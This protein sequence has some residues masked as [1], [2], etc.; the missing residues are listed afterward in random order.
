M[1]RMC[2]ALLKRTISWCHA[3]FYNLTDIHHIYIS[4]QIFYQHPLQRLRVS[5]YVPCSKLF[6]CFE[7]SYFSRLQLKKLKR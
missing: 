3:F 7:H 1:H 2:A 4:R 5:W 6:T